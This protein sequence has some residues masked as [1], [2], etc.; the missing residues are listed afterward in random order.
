MPSS[1]PD[2][3]TTGN[4][5]NPFLPGAMSDNHCDRDTIVYRT[6]LFI[7]PKWKNLFFMIIKIAYVQKNSI[8]SS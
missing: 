4:A 5:H 3:S 2:P 8:C 7:F 6:L 1:R